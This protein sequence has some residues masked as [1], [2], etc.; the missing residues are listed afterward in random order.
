MNNNRFQLGKIYSIQAPGIQGVYI[1]STTEPTLARRMAG[2]RTSMAKYR[3][4]AGSYITS[5][6]ILESPNAFIR[7]I[8][9]FPCNSKDNLLAREQHFINI[10]ENVVNK[11]KAFTGLTPEEYHKQYNIQYYDAN[12]QQITEHNKQYYDANK[13]QI[14]EHH[15]QYYDAN[16]EQIQEHHKQYYEANKEQITEHK[17]QKHQ[18]GCGGK[19]TTTHKSRHLNSN[20]H[21]QYIQHRQGLINKLNDAFGEEDW[22]DATNDEMQAIILECEL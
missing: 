22:L 15:K 19:Y 20:Q 12:K 9:D 1:G 6:Q 10:T 8:E 2:H 21:Q 4:G 16:K 14:Q 17:N 7:L 18:C 13:E 5:F 11:Y 3:R